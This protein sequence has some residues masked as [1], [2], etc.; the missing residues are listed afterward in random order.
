MKQVYVLLAAAAALASAGCDGDQSGQSPSGN[1]API[2]AVAPPPGGD[3]TKMVTQTAEGGFLMGNPNADVKLVEYASMTC[4]HCADFAESGTQP[5]IDKYVK[6]GRVSFELRNYVRDGLDMAMSLVAR[7]GGPE[8]FFPLTDTL[9]KSQRSFFEKIGQAS[10]QS[11]QE[12]AQLAGLQ[13]WAAQ[14]GLPSARSSAC[15]ANQQQAERLVQ[16][17]TDTQTQYPA[18]R[19][20]PSFTINGELLENAASWPELEPKIRDALG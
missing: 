2:E 19:G 14:R 8:R 7:C 10:A 11:P 3:W 16:M 9:F 4:P 18:F 15:L 1:A 17:T 13:Q 20:T 12:F 6:T 5:L